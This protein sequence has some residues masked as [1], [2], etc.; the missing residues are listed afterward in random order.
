MANGFLPLFHDHSG[1]PG[2]VFSDTGQT[3][4]PF[5][6]ILGGLTDEVGVNRDNFVRGAAFGKP[7]RPNCRLTDLP[8]P[9]I[10]PRSGELGGIIMRQIGK[11][12]RRV[13]EALLGLEERLRV[14]EGHARYV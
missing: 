8:L 4:K 12:R 6:I 7:L 1:F 9:K 14:G 3:I 13:Q 10:K 5:L 11:T 2:D